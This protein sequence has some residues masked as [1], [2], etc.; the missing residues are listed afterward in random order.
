MHVTIQ[1]PN[2]ILSPYIK[3]MVYYT[4]YVPDYFATRMLPEP[5]IELLFALDEQPRH[6]SKD[7][8]TQ[9]SCKGVFV[10]GMQRAPLV[11]KASGK[12]ML[13]VTFKPGGSSPFLHLPQS[14]LN[15]LFVDADLIFGK[16][17]WQLRECL[18]ECKTVQKMFSLTEQFL[19]KC[20]VSTNTHQIIQESVKRLQSGSDRMS[21]RGLSR[22][23]G[24]SQKQFIALFKQ[25][26]GITPKLYQ[27]L[28]RFNMA[29]DEIYAAVEPDWHT[30]AYTFGFFDQAHF[31]NE[32]KTFSGS[33]PTVYLRSKGDYP[34]YVPLYEKTDS[35]V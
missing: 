11:A 6:F 22:M 31:I 2:Q 10:A 29:L 18:L 4:D 3:Q 25:H 33:S 27:R 35:A 26:V 13:V 32:F 7:R 5:S 21:I 17:I 23:S 19:L 16:K 14:E 15:D 9:F 24:Y 28:N 34:N 1:A 20:M 8:N 12:T 30:I